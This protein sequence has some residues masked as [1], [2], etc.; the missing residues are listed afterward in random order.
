MKIKNEFKTSIQV[1]LMHCDD[2]RTIVA[3]K[4]YVFDATNELQ[5]LAKQLKSEQDIKKKIKIQNR[6]KYLESAIKDS[7]DQLSTMS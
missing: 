2:K 3:I 4:Q 7:K 1:N 5:D 6:I